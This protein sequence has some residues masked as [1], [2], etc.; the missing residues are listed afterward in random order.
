LT[1]LERL[2]RNWLIGKHSDPDLSTTSNTT[3]H[4][5]TTSFNLTRSHPASADGFQTE[6]T[7]TDLGAPQRQTAVAAFV[8]FSKF[9]S[10]WL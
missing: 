8:H 5:S 3:G 1:N 6:L 2:L 7:K 9:R 10:F 4:R